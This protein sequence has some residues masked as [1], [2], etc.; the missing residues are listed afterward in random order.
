MH[1]K[2]LETLEFAKVKSLFEEFLVTEQGRQELLELGP[3]DQL[4]KIQA[5]FLEVS[6]MEQ[7]F[8]QHPQ[9][10]LAATQNVTE[11]T[12]RLELGGDLSIEEFL[13]LKRL[14]SVSHQLVDFYANLENVQLERLHRLF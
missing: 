2:I 1:K 4:E 13:T 6:D 5:S 8:V 12:R 10:S 7:I 14:L 3:S 11:I 9:F